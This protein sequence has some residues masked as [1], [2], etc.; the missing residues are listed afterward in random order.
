MANTPI[1]RPQVS[2]DSASAM[3]TPVRS[4][5]AFAEDLVAGEERTREVSWSREGKTFSGLLRVRKENAAK[6]LA[7]T[8]CKDVFRMK[9]AK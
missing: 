3:C 5:Q 6:K 9:S 1:R 4:W 7:C 8:R 2:R